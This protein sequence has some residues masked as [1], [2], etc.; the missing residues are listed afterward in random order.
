MILSLS[1]TNLSIE[2]ES[3]QRPRKTRFLRRSAPN[4]KRERESTTNCAKREKLN[5]LLIRQKERLKKL[6][7]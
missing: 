1:K 3:L 4:R 5:M 2:L 7:N 6:K